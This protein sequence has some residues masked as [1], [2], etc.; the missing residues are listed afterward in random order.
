MWRK[1][2]VAALAL[3]ALAGAWAIV[4]ALM[5]SWY[6]RHVYPLSH[7]AEIRAAATRNGLDPALVAA[8][9][10]EESRFRDDVSSHQGAVGLMQVLP[11]TAQEIARQTGGTDWTLGDLA[12]PRVNTL[13]GSYYLRELLD[14]YG[15]SELAAVAAYNAGQGNVDAWLSQ[16]RAAGRPLRVRDLPFAETRAYVGDVLRLQKIYRRTYGEEL[17]LRR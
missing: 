5:P 15:G 17:G 13:Y 3:G 6:A 9:I 10:Y 4:D 7:A 14:R 1:L 12:D 11:S 8:V 16:A 2:A